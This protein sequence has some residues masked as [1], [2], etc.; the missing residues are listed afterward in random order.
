LLIRTTPAL[1]QTD[2]DV[3][4]NKAQPA[5]FHGVLVSDK[6]Y[7]TYTDLI[8]E[9]N[10][11]QAKTFELEPGQC[12][13]FSTELLTVGGISVAVGIGLGVMVWAAIK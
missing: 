10:I 13:D 3:E 5:P 8:D 7:K 11:L 4:L 12:P 2:F 9:R 6:R 1:A